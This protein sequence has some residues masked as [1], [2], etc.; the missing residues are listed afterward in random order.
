MNLITVIIE[1][2]EILELRV[3]ENAIKEKKYG[4]EIERL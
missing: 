1:A 2:E 3:K 4:E